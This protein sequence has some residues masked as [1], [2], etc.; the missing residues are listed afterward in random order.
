MLCPRG[1]RNDGADIHN[2]CISSFS[3]LSFLCVAPSYIQREN[4]CA[5]MRVLYLL[6]SASEV[7][8]CLDC[9]QI[10]INVSH[11]TPLSLQYIGT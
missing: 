2:F 10:D 9:L 1:K 5:D 11:Q 3:H 4:L 8:G 7:D 6:V